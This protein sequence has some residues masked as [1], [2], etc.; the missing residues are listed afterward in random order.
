[1][2]IA[3]IYHSVSGNTKKTAELIA[4]GARRQ[5]GVEVK[6]MGIDDPDFD[7]LEESKCV[8]FGTPTYLGNFSWQIKKFLDKDLKVKLNGKLGGVFATEN[9]LGGGADFALMNLIGHLLVKGM[10]VYSSGVSEGEPY[11]HFGAV[12]I[13]DGD[14]QQKERATIFGERLSKKALEIFCD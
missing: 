8:I 5:E 14:V 6:T 7:F 1:M 12:C 9:F 10:L 3:V 11:T 13:K 4:A 2:K